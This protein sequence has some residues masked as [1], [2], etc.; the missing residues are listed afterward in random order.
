MHYVL[1]GHR[2][3]YTDQTYLALFDSLYDYYEAPSIVQEENNED[4]NV[5]VESDA[6]VEKILSYLQY[7]IQQHQ[8]TLQ[9][10]NPRDFT[11]LYLLE[12]AKH[13]DRIEPHFT[14][15]VLKFCLFELF[16]TSLLPLINSLKWALLFMTNN[17]DI[18]ENVQAELDKGFGVD[19]QILMNYRKQLPYTLATLH[20]SLRLSSITALSLPL[21]PTGVN[22][23]SASPVS[24]NANY[25]VIP[26][27]SQ[28]EV[29]G[30]HIPQD[31]EVNINEQYNMAFKT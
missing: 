14:L 13:Q 6:S 23:S 21:Q 22:S 8:T 2:M 19:H 9:I 27:K 11:D 24:T 1:F 3:N 25:K 26:L 31:S 30:Y 29:C 15:E 17:Y 5:Q 10:D 12:I 7:K 4:L 28:Y 16:V 20:E 18:Q